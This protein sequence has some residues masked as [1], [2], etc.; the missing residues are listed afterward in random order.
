M[1][2]KEPTP[3]ELINEVYDNVKIAQISLHN[4]KKNEDEAKLLTKKT[5]EQFRLAKDAQNAL[6]GGLI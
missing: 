4:A 2:T 3:E 6:E 5:R 1:P